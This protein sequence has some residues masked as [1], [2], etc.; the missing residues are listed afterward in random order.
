[1]NF[2]FANKWHE[3]IKKILLSKRICSILVD[4]FDVLCCIT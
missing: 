4:S 2:V 1:M 3:K